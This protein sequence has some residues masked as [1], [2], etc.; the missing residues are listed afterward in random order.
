MF[1]FRDAES[2]LRGDSAY[3]SWIVCEQTADDEPVWFTVA[4]GQEECGLGAESPGEEESARPSS[5]SPSEE[6]DP[7]ADQDSRYAAAVKARVP[8]LEA[9]TDDNLGAQGQLAC[10]L[11]DS[12]DSPTSVV[13]TL[14]AAYPH[15]AGRVMVVEAP[16]VYCPRYTA[17]VKRALK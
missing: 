5:S 11:L 6:T 2:H 3:D 12:G 7:T 13:E 16:P 1:G 17:Q 4:A 8:D 15:D 9:V 10:T 14:Q